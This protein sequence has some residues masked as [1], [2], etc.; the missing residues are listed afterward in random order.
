MKSRKGKQIALF[1]G[2]II[3]LILTIT[4][5][6]VYFNRNR[7][8][9]TIE[10]SQYPR[11]GATLF[12]ATG[13]G[14]VAPEDCYLIQD[15]ETGI[16]PHVF[17]GDSYILLKNKQKMEVMTNEID[18]ESY[19]RVK[20]EFE[21]LDAVFYDLETGE[22]TRKIDM[23]DIIK[24]ACPGFQ[25]GGALSIVLGE[26]GHK[27]I[28]LELENIPEKAA[29]EVVNKM[30]FYDIDTGDTFTKDSE[31][32]WLEFLRAGYE[33][34]DKEY[35]M[36]MEEVDWEWNKLLKKGEKEEYITPGVNVVV[37]EARGCVEVRID[38]S[39]LPEKNDI[40]YNRFPNLKEYNELEGKAAYIYIGGYPTADEIKAMFSEN[41]DSAGEL[42]TLQT[43]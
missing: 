42:E 7:D 11:E 23:L 5:L 22:E 36:A 33:K 28:G 9:I 34:K 14:N 25:K 37:L 21:Y 2:I 31:E 29:D 38:C 4:G 6:T 24:E 41:A 15:R 30:L 12:D 27:Y 13:K 3:V 20:G 8:E 39:L 43:D 10:N 17:P 35:G 40:L 16:F 19:T 26:D 1:C 18:G 32:E